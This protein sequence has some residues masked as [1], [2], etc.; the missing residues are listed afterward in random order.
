VLAQLEEHLIAH[1]IRVLLAG[2]QANNPGAIRFWTG[3]GFRI[4][5]EPQ[6]MPDGTTAMELEKRLDGC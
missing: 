4:I 3:H 6:L 1:G 5:S 2:V